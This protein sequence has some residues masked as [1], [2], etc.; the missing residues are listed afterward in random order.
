M[1]RVLA[2][3]EI[4]KEK[5]KIQHNRKTTINCNYTM[6][7]CSINHK[8]TLQH[9][10]H[11]IINQIPN[12]NFQSTKEKA[13]QSAFIRKIPRIKDSFEGISIVQLKSFMALLWFWIVWICS[14]WNNAIFTDDE[15]MM[16]NA[17]RIQILETEEPFW[18]HW[19]S[20]RN[21]LIFLLSLP[22]S[23]SKPVVVLSLLDQI[24]ERPRIRYVNMF[25]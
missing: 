11:I 6:F 19:K 10:S 7:F 4:E 14:E 17:F 23:F 3:L 25:A 13:Q 16:L 18:N 12:K 24:K 1:V 21:E 9:I 20:L 22:F 2:C 5:Q 8:R 15:W